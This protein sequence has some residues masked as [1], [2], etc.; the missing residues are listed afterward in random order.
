ME[1]VRRT[2]LSYAVLYYRTPYLWTYAVL[3][4]RTPYLWT[5]D[6]TIMS[7]WPYAQ[8]RTTTYVRTRPISIWSLDPLHRLGN[9][10]PQRAWFHVIDRNQDELQDA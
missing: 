9:D 10:D 2:L 1:I 3:Y 5:Y 7:V 4:Y 6:R 8:E